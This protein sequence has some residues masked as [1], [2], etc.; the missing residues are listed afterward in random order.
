MRWT[1]FGVAAALALAAAASTADVL[2]IRA[3]GPSA[4]R[5]PAGKRL[6]DAA[7]VT[8]QRGDTVVLLDRHG[9]R[10]V[11]G[12]GSF[13]AAGNSSG[14][15][16]SALAALTAGTAGRRA[17]V[18]AVRNE[19]T[20][21]ERRPG[22]FLVDVAAAG[23]TCLADRAAV[24]LWRAASQEV[25][26][27]VITPRVGASASVSWIKGQSTQPWPEA[28]PTADG[29]SYR[30]VTDPANAAPRA[31]VEITF[32]LLKGAPADLSQLAQGLIAARCQAQIDLLVATTQAVP[33]GG[34]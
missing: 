27:S 26:T 34:N 6:P 13:T 7:R 12:P 5:F 14:P 24:T 21:P 22:I 3:S 19:P 33:G 11:A 4:A 28:L 9:T 1:E 25:A 30:I 2:V 8:L 23:R 32:A 20:G 31:P 18:G 29:A 10:S 15:T 16:P 17:R